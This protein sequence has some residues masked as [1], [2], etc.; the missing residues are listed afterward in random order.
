MMRMKSVGVWKGGL[1]GHATVSRRGISIIDHHH[2][3]LSLHDHHD[4]FN[5]GT[6]DIVTISRMV[7]TG[8]L[9]IMYIVY[10]RVNVYCVYCFIG[11]I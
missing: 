11:L 2:D 9:G 10:I 4:H 6:E 8:I 3:H 1:V 7:Y 5:I